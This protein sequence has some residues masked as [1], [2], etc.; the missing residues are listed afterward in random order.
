MFLF[1]FLDDNFYTKKTC[2]SN[3]EWLLYLWCE[4]VIYNSNTRKLMFLF[5]CYYYN[6]TR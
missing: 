2:T 3:A 6:F 5:D 1:N 4:H